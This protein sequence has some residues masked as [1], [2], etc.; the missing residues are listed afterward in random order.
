MKK[1]L[2]SG[3]GI[4]LSP[5]LAHQISQHANFILNK[6]RSIYHMLP[7]MSITAGTIL[8]FV[9]CLFP[10]KYIGAQEQ[11]KENVWKNQPEKIVINNQLSF[12]YQQ[13]MSSEITVVHL[14]IK[15]GKRAVPISQRGLSFIT[16]GL[17]MEMPD[18]DEVRR[19]MEL[20]TSHVYHIHSDFVTIS[21]R[22]LSQNLAKSLHIIT[23]VLRKPLFSSLRIG[24]VKR[25]L[26]HKQKSEKDS[27]EQLMDLTF[28]NTLFTS[29][30]GSIYGDA[31]SLKNLK[32][33][34]VID[35]YNHFFNLANMI[36]AISTNLSKTEIIPI[37]EKNFALFPQGELQKLEKVEASIPKKKEIFIKKDNQQVLI[38]FGAMLP[39]MSRQ[40]F[41]MIYMLENLLGKGIGS[42]LWP[43]RAKKELAY[44]LKSQFSQL[45]EAGLLTILLKSDISKRQEA[46]KGLKKLLTNIYENGVTQKDLD[47]AKVRSQADFL[48]DNETKVSRSQWI[49]YF[50]ALGVGFDYLEKFFSNID[51]VTLEQFNSYLKKVLNP[52][53]LIEVVIGEEPIASER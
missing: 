29:Y 37:I 36:I 45:E 50:E 16:T 38:S 25:Y 20:G 24:N 13:D 5:I 22:S 26:E 28:F 33:K 51:Q 21:I 41:A 12:I 3:G 7:K 53:R 47:I 31:Q 52:H 34:D 8:F 46:H 44:S 9:L 30:S 6:K 14:L 11:G 39:R 10:S 18:M 17:A 15:G 2:T 49:A 43:L 48:R 19:L 27:P 40:N 42:K 35:F 4:M 1:S 32:R 23:R